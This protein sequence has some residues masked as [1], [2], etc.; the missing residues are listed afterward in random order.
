M[1]PEQVIS[2][3]EKLF[4]YFD[5][6]GLDSKKIKNH[7]IFLQ[8][9]VHKS[10]AADFKEILPHNE[11]L[12]FL[13]DGVLGAII[14]KLL[15]QDHPDMHES[16]MTLYK[17]ALVREETLSMVAQNI[18]LAKMLFISKGEEKS[19]G[20]QKDAILSDALEA[21]IGYIFVDFGYQQTEEFVQKYVYSMYDKIDK[22]PVKS[23]KTMV[24]EHVQKHYKQIPEYQ[25]VEDQVDSSGNVLAYK[26]SLF[27]QGKEVSIGFSTNKKKAQEEAA[28]NFYNTI[29]D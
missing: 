5:T 27:V 13:G 22:N 9:F 8:T 17:I 4:K 10:Y 12:E 16:D 25:E 23:Y 18:G 15:F 20:R 28:K 19:Q 1:F 7:N 29:D 14:C 6:L 2:Q 11:R 24:Q 21:L 3:K 26:S